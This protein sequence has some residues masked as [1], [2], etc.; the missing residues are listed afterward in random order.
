MSGFHQR[1]VWTPKSGESKYRPSSFSAAASVASGSVLVGVDS[2]V[3]PTGTGKG[4]GVKVGLGM[5]VSGGVVAVGVGAA[6]LL[7]AIRSRGRIMDR[8]I[9]L[10]RRKFMDVEKV[11]GGRGVL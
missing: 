7:Q 2:A 3:T 5:G 9:I 6:S 8:D 11:N 1:E 4:V 10:W